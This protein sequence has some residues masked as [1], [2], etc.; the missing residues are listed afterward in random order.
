MHDSSMMK[1][2]IRTAEHAAEDAGAR[3]VTAVRVRVGSLSGISPGHLREHYEDAAA[4][5]LLEGSFLEIEEG[6][7]GMNAL[8]DPAAQGVL[9]VGIDVEDD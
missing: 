5:T 6:P 4:G 7:D 1:G 3:R 2:L 9:L 8:D